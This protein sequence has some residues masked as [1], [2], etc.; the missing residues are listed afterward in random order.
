MFPRLSSFVE[1]DSFGFDDVISNIVTSH[2]ETMK[3]D[4]SKAEFDLVRNPFLVIYIY[5][6]IY[7]IE[8]QSCNKRQK[9]E[10]Q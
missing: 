6:Y 10:K 4:I 2:L 1:D 9:V 7:Q 8:I 5:I 3:S